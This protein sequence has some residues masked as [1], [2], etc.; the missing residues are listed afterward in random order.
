M[1]KNITLAVEDEVLERVRVVAAENRTTVNAMVREY[2]SRVVSL[3]RIEETVSR[4]KRPVARSIPQEQISQSAEAPYETA[5][6]K[7]QRL[8]NEGEAKY[9]DRKWFDREE[10][11]DRDYQRAELYF[12]NRAALLN[13]I[14]ETTADMGTQKWNREALYDR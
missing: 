3:S 8:L 12:E 4:L 9:A 5:H 6:E 13:L 1:T 11:Y 7:M 10:I 2:L 14:D